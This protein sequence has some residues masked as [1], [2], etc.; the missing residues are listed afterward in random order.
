MIYMKGIA[1]VSVAILA[2]LV[3]AGSALASPRS[4]TCRVSVGIVTASG[5]TSCPFANN[6]ATA[7]FL[8][9]CRTVRVCTGWA[10]S[11]VTHWRYRVT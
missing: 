11:P 7:W 4:H 6:I 8:G 5:F 2:S 3:F 9:G 10:Y 1:V